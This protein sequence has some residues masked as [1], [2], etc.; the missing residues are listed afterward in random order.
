MIIDEAQR[1]KDPTTRLSLAVK[2]M[3][4]DFAIAL[5]GPPVENSWVDFGA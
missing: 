1:I 5:R 3:K 4:Y 2:A